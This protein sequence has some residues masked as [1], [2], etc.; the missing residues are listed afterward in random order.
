[1]K[2]ERLRSEKGF[3]LVGFMALM[4]LLLAVLSFI[5][6]VVMIMKTNSRLTHECRTELLGRQRSVS[7]QLN[8]LIAMNKAAAILR[9]ERKAAEALVVSTAPLPP[10]HAAAVAA[11]NVVKA[12]QAAFKGA[13]QFLIV[14]ARTQS[15]YAPG[16]A[17][18]NL[19]RVLNEEVNAVSSNRA[20]PR[21]QSNRPYVDLVESPKADASP[22]Y[23]PS[24]TFTRQQEMKVSLE[25]DLNSVLPGWL[26]AL[27]PTKGLRLKTNCS[28]T[29]EKENSKWIEKLSAAR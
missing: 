9:V 1:M 23:N 6:G 24:E 18:F 29:I 3:G 12:Q 2:I 22:D 7:N 20:N 11:L 13:Q 28:A 19:R 10:A 26:K 5:S 27:L 17:A 15:S 21:T 25:V 4:P 14:T 16:I 8:Q